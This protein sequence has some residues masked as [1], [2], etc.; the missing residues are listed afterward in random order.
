[1][2]CPQDARAG[3]PRRFRHL[4]SP[5]AEAFQP[6][7]LH[8]V[9]TSNTLH[10]TVQTVR[11]FGVAVQPCD[12]RPFLPFRVSVSIERAAGPRL[13][14]PR[15]TSAVP[16]SRLATC[17]ARGQDDRSLRV[18]RVTFL[19]HTRRIYAASVRMTLGFESIG[20][21]AHRVVASYAVRVPRAR[22]LPFASFRFRVAPNTLAVRLG[23]PVIKA[24]I[25]TFT[26]QVTSRLAFA[27][28]FKA[29]GHDASRHA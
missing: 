17:L 7:I 6:A 9:R 11:P 19:P 4:L 2:P 8:F 24:S 20:P 22:S 3:Y 23:V 1:M 26:Q 10:Q 5:V 21:L 13:L 16:S 18:R 28:R 25:G 12:P 27:H 14:W 29:S 15:L